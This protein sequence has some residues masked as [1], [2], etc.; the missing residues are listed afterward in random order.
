MSSL[1]LDSSLF[2]SDP[3][4]IKNSQG[5]D[6]DIPWDPSRVKTKRYP[7]ITTA[8]LLAL[9]GLDTNKLIDGPTLYTDILGRFS[10]I[11]EMHNLGNSI[12]IGDAG[13]LTLG[14]INEF[15][16]EFNEFIISVLD[17]GGLVE[18]INVGLVDR[19]RLRRS[20]FSGPADIINE[21]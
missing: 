9:E 16:R 4:I 15:E 14:Q 12:Y 17:V 6:Q 2:V 7:I 3:I 20:S 21:S 8:E 18:G 10:V 11:R 1:V 13:P 19:G 5:V